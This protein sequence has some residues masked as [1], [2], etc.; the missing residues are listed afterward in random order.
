MREQMT[1]VPEASASRAPSPVASDSA[2]CTWP[3]AA[4]SSAA[5]SATRQRRRQAHEVRDTQLIDQRGHPRPAAGI[6]PGSAC[7][8]QHRRVVTFRPHRRAAQRAYRGQHGEQVGARV[9]ASADDEEAL[10]QS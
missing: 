9:V 7:Q 4:A 3:T 1:G 5:R 2:A 10:G 8:H 6:G